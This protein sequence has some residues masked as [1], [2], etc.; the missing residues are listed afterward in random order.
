M[1][2]TENNQGE[3]GLRQ[4]N[5]VSEP[6][7]MNPAVGQGSLV[8]DESSAPLH[9][10]ATARTTDLHRSSTSTTN[11]RRRYSAARRQNTFGSQR[12]SLGRVFTDMMRPERPLKG[13]PT[14]S[15]SFKAVVIHSWLNLLLVCVPISFALNFAI[16][17]DLATFIVSF[18]AIIPL[19][20][21][22]LAFDRLKLLSAHPCHARPTGQA[23]R[24][25]YRGNCK[26]CCASCWL[27]IWLSG[28]S[29][30]CA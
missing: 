11:G 2:T 6:E 4:R 24:I 28:M 9:E 17:S 8:T 23:P 27:S 21:V 10:N 15:Q 14:Y 26:L 5:M 30:L 7:E 25:R 22:P 19:V 3:D 20:S 1:S 12:P 29:R 13:T 18:L 16:D